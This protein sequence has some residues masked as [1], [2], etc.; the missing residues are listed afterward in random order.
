MLDNIIIS[1]SGI[2][3]VV[4]V[5]FRI[6]EIIFP[7]LN[8]LSA[9]KIPVL[10]SE[11]VVCSVTHAVTIITF[12]WLVEISKSRSGIRSCVRKIIP[13]IGQ[14][15]RSWITWALS[16]SLKCRSLKNWWSLSL[17]TLSV[18]WVSSILVSSHRR[19][20]TLIELKL[21]FYLLVRKSWE[22]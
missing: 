2:C 15:A 10:M 4:C 13:G 3:S 18:L 16:E 19:R 21:E 12:N 11:T 14:R 9:W 22:I 6:S 17:S 1:V 5:S 8:W 7:T 20:W